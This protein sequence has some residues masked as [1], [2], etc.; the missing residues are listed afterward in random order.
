M[1][2]LHLLCAT[3][4][5]IL[6]QFSFA[7][8]PQKIKSDKQISKLHYYTFTGQISQDQ[9]E[10]LQQDLKNMAFVIE[11]KIEYKAEKAAGQVRLISKENEVA[12]EGDKTFS[13]VD[14]K[15]TLVAKGLMPVEYRN[16]II[17]TQ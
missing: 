2:F 16:E 14:I 10:F 3:A 4:F 6:S 12:G 5:I 9:I 8:A 13:A 1:R 11:V 15:R 17:S 7:Q